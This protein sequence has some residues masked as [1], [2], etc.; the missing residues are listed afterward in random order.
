MT[1][2]GRGW[3]ATIL[4][5][6]SSLGAS[7]A[8]IWITLSDKISSLSFFYTFLQGSGKDAR[9]KLARNVLLIT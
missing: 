9:D 5:Q 3:I 2:H 4:F 8:V 7:R 1:G 6:K